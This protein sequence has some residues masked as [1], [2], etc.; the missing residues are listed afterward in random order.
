M[1]ER[2][3]KHSLLEWVGAVLRYWSSTAPVYGPRIWPP[4]MDPVLHGDPNK[5]IE[6]VPEEH[7]TTCQQS[8]EL[9]KSPRSSILFLCA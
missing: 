7:E 5:H 3:Q 1:R 6:R 8:P 2:M 4:Y 9:D